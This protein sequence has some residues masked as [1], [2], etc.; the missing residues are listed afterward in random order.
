MRRLMSIGL[1]CS[2]LA[3]ALAVPASASANH[4][5]AARIANR[6]HHRHHHARRSSRTI[7][8]SPSSTSPNNETTPSEGPTATIASYEGGRLTL[9]LADGSTVSGQV[10]EYT[11]ID[12]ACPGYA[13]YGAG[14]TRDPGWHSDDQWQQPQGTQGQGYP[15]QP[16]DGPPQQP[17][18]PSCDNTSLLVP[19]AAVRF[20]QLALTET[21]AVWESV[22]LAQQQ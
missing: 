10:T 6:R 13:G 8:F 22:D 1:L 14:Q 12:C 11:R 17:Q 7:V 3:V 21:G 15:G 18:P 4:S 2:A 19:G 9:T 20:A 5:P 16:G